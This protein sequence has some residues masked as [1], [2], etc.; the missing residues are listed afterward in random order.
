MTP[1]QQ[2]QFDLI[3]RDRRRR[4]RELLLAMLLLAAGGRSHA[5]ASVRLGFDPVAA[6]RVIWL[7]DGRL[8]HPGVAPAYAK[9]T[10]AAH[11]DGYRRAGLL[12]GVRV[13][14]PPPS[15]SLAVV[16]LAEARA[17]AAA[18]FDTL[19]E[20]L[21]AALSA[22]TGVAAKAG[23]VIRRAFEAAGWTAAN[24]YA[25]ARAAEHAVVA[26]HGEGYRAGFEDPTVG[27][28]LTGF[29]FAAVLDGSTTDTCRS[30]DGLRFATDSPSW[31][32]NRPP[33]HYGC[34]SVLL[35][36]FG[37][38]AESDPPHALPPAAPGFGY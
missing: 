2:T 19:A 4:E 16:W 30:R 27:A 23:S 11:N 24:P 14:P 35:P 36:V 21:R 5:A 20:K 3:E 15:P 28:R 29:R 26:A 10:T 17:A 6:A 38:F 33:L 9:V 34:R 8:G 12:A 32:G 25:L 31:D 7:G 18:M 13:D 22:F 1:T 37:P